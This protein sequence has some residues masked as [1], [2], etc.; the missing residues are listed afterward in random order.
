MMHIVREISNHI[1][2]DRPLHND[3]GKQVDNKRSIIASA[4]ARPQPLTMMIESMHAVPTEVA[5]KGTLRSEYLA[6]VAE[7]NS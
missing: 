1:Y 6:R 7:F 4:Y 5:V 3:N 2:Q